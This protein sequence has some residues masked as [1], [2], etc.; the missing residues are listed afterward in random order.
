[1][2]PTQALGESSTFDGRTQCSG[3]SAQQILQGNTDGMC[4]RAFH[5][6]AREMGDSGVDLFAT[7]LN[8]QTLV[9]ISPCPDLNALALDA[10]SLDWSTLPQQSSVN[11]I[12]VAPAWPTLSWF[13]DLLNLSMAAQLEFL[14]VPELLSQMVQHK[15]WTYHKNPGIYNYHAWML[16]GIPS[17]REA[18]LRRL[19]TESQSHNDLLPDPS[20]LGSGQNSV[21]GV[22]EGRQIQSRPLFL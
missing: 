3:G 21:L 17:Q 14:V 6:I 13:P 10:L 11:I 5:T 9:Y 19:V 12:L 18:F 22:V 20:M 16:P 2:S 4:P 8:Y 15:T 1:M 7:A